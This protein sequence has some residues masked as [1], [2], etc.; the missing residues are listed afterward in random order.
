MSNSQVGRKVTLKGLKQEF[1]KKKSMF[2]Q[3]KASSGLPELSG[4]ELDEMTLQAVVD[5]QLRNLGF[6]DIVTVTYDD[7]SEAD[8]V[9][10]LEK[11]EKL[12]K[13]VVEFFANTKSLR[14]RLF[15][16]LF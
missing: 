5:D 10:T 12:I 3:K 11:L 4:P 9:I 7:E 6:N 14:S 15:L 13:K 2:Q 16:Y 8:E 1:E